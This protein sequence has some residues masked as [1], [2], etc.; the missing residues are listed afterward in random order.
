V[1][2]DEWGEHDCGVPDFYF[3]VTTT[4][5]D[6]VADF[7]GPS[8][9][10][11]PRKWNVSIFDWTY[12][13]VT[14]PHRLNVEYQLIDV[15]TKTCNVSIGLRDAA[16]YSE[17]KRK[18]SAL[19]AMS[20]ALGVEPLIAQFVG[21]H[22]LDA[23]SAIN[24]PPADPEDP[25]H[26]AA[27]PIRSGEEPVQVWWNQP[28]LSLLPSGTEVFLDSESAQAAA[29]LLQTWIDLCDRMPRLRVLEE[30]LVNAPVSVSY[31]QATLSVW[32]ALESLFPSVQTE[33]TY[34]VAMYLTQLVRPS[35][36][37]AY[38]KSVRSAY[39]QRSKIAHGSV[40]STRDEIAAWRGAWA[41]LCDATLAITRR[42]GLP[43][44]EDLTREML[45]RP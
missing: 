38:L 29:E 11:S 15:L 40:S 4:S 20:C 37:L 41:L 28:T 22:P 14:S 8:L 17:A 33:V 26:A 35:D 10:L 27:A 42:G 21:T 30:V 16:D 39:G 34:R 2:G 44:E 43:A 5:S 7:E 23:L 19:R 25:R 9:I 1:G 32:G 12:L 13:A 45:M 3:Y 6:P 31:P 36:P 24:G 18:F